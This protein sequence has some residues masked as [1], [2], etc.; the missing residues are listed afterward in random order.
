[1]GGMILGR[2]WPS[3]QYGITPPRYIGHAKGRQK[4]SANDLQNSFKH[5]AQKQ[6]SE[7][8]EITV[9]SAAQLLDYSGHGPVDQSSSALREAQACLDSLHEDATMD[10]QEW[11]D[12][13][14]SFGDAEESENRK[15]FYEFDLDGNQMMDV[16]ELQIALVKVGAVLSKTLPA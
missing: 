5:F 10:L 15:V 6:G 7:G 12:V 11:M 3:P 16:R 2:D 13:Y 1:M 9:R 14:N 4:A 8:G